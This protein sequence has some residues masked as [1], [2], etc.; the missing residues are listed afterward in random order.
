[1]HFTELKRQV[2]PNENKEQREKKTPRENRTW[3]ENS[4]N[5]KVKVKS[6]A[7]ALTLYTQ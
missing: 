7:H 5:G 1:M 3:N 6:V 2:P 4:P